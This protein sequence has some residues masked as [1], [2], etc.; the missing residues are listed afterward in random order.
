MQVLIIA[1]SSIMKKQYVCLIC[2]EFTSPGTEYAT[3][4]WEFG[5]RIQTWRERHHDVQQTIE[6]ITAAWWESASPS[7]L[8]RNLPPVLVGFTASWLPIP[9]CILAFVSNN[10]ILRHFTKRK[11]K[12]QYPSLGTRKQNFMESMC[13]FVS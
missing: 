2:A 5:L 13:L 11:K 4:V 8:G 12:F 3:L 9:K 7:V 6:V 1:G 10:V